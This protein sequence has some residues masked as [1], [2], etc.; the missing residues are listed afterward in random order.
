MAHGRP[1]APPRPGRNLGLGR[2]SRTAARV[3]RPTGGPLDLS[4]L[5]RSNDRPRASLNQKHNGSGS[6]KNPNPFS[7]LF[8]LSSPRS[9]LLPAAQPQRGESERADDGGRA[10]P[11][12][13]RRPPRRRACSLAG[14]R[15]AVERS[16][17]GAPLAR[18]WRAAPPARPSSPRAPTSRTTAVS[19][20]VE[21]GLPFPFFPF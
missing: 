8:S 20:A 15:A 9:S 1:R 19:A 17:C 13:H 2:Q 10:E 5:R 6:P 3:P 4:R 21:A 11:W 14:E 18:S 7:S 12:R 16:G